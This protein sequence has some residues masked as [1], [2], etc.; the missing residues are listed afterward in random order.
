M[1]SH[2]RFSG[3]GWLHGTQLLSPDTFEQLAPPSSLNAGTLI[4]G[5][6]GGG[7]GGGFGGSADPHP[8]NANVASPATI[9]DAVL[10]NMPPL[11]FGAADHRNYETTR[12]ADRSVRPYGSSSATRRDDVYRA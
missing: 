2:G 4:S 3:S 1:C 11:L 6:C 8:A 5:G 7:G 10:L 9:A 12:S